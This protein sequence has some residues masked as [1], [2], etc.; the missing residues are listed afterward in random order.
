MPKLHV[1]YPS[2]LNAQDTYDKVKDLLD[3]DPGLRKLDSSYQC[4]FDDGSLCGSAKGGMF[5]AE[6]KVASQGAKSNVNLVID[7]PLMFIAFKGQVKSTLEKKLKE[8]LG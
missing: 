8:T 2:P 4:K 1:D 3:K 7:L 5:S 6:L